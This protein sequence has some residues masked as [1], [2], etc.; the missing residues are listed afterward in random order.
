MRGIGTKLLIAFL[1]S[2]TVFLA[3][4]YF[5]NINS[6]APVVVLPSSVNPTP[7][8]TVSIKLSTRQKLAQLLAVPLVLPQAIAS[9]S[10]EQALIDD[11]NDRSIE[12][13]WL[14][15]NQAGIVIYY[16]QAI[17]MQDAQTAKE[18][19]R[20]IYS[21]FLYQPLIAVDHEGGTVQRLSGSG[22]S[23]LDSWQ[24]L[25]NKYD[26]SAQ[27][28]ALASSASQLAEVGV[29][30]V[31]APVV[32]LEQ[33]ERILRSRAASDSAAVESAA[34]NFIN[35]FGQEKIMPVLK[36]F[37]GIG[38][39]RT[40]LHFSSA[41]ISLTAEETAIFSSILD[42]YPNIGVMS[43]H[44]RLNNKFNGEL[45]SLSSE[46]LGPLKKSY[47][48]TIVFSDD[49]MMNSARQQE[50]T[51]EKV[52]L[53]ELAVKALRAGNDILL[54]GPSSTQGDLNQVLSRLELEYADSESFRQV[55]E[56]SLKKILLLKS[57]QVT[58]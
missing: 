19:L 47:P 13:S 17:T 54:F 23:Q 58:N 44:V 57:S 21:S 9:N 14:A 32:D 52:E 37:P 18:K 30:I 48:Q 46:C 56:T 40:D 20:E 53:G 7:T 39:I 42:Q 43:T 49:L 8:P 51:D 28:T 25:V 11:S 2:L 3:Y 5:K 55:V 45:C 41:S 27:E 50:S 24:Q 31:F 22:F 6:Q 16:G 36:H 15:E 26:H 12:L 33:E 1:F 35:V 38:S 29:N 34:I 10:S 4:L